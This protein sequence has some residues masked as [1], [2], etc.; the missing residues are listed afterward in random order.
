MGIRLGRSIPPTVDDHNIFAIILNT[1]NSEKI[2][3]GI[4]ET[5]PDYYQISDNCF[6]V[7]S[8]QIADEVANTIKLKGPDRI[9]ETSGV[10][11]KLNG[12]YAGYSYQS[13]WDWMDLKH[14]SRGVKF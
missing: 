10:V 1:P 13:L 3:K 11:F 7:S 14:E 4:K 12:S 5:Y 6:L 8:P 9:E 2:E